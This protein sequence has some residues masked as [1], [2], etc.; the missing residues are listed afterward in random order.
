MAVLCKLLLA[1]IK[2]KSI[3]ILAKTVIRKLE[4]IIIGVADCHNFTGGRSLLPKA[5]DLL[6][7]ET[8][9]QASVLWSSALLLDHGTL[10]IY[11]VSLL[12]LVAN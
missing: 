11:I 6:L 8:N 2:C 1:A 7:R 4:S 10:T 3:S 9:P 12:R 5:R